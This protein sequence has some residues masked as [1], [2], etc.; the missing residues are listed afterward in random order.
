MRIL[1]LRLAAR[2]LGRQRAF[3]TG[4]LGLR[5]V[6]ES[7][8]DVTVQ[9]GVSRLRFEIAKRETGVYHLAFTVP[10]NRLT[11]AREWLL[12]RT[13]L[14]TQG[15]QDRFTSESWNAEQVY[16]ED[17]EGNVLE[18]IARHELSNPSAALFGPAGLLNVSEV[19]YAVPDVAVTVKRLGSHL[20]L[21]PYRAPGPTFA[22]LGDAHGLLIVAALGR[23]WFPT[24][25][26][27]VALPL[28]LTLQSP[29]AFDYTKPGLPYRIRG[30]AADASP[31][32]QP[33]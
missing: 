6:G 25:K 3:Y 8:T 27:A 13:R 17:A 18:L 23:P 21:E 11:Q 19:G 33:T 9:A 15:V 16:F 24:A 5:V 22:P 30:V 26:G 10:A 32:A 12:A 1:E 4:V 29:V 20:A 28:E 31:D 14:L 2:D 7:S